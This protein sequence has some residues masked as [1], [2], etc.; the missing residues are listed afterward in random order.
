MES[1]EIEQDVRGLIH[2]LMVE[3]HVEN[4]D[5]HFDG[6]SEAGDNYA[7][8]IL[9]LRVVPKDGKK[10]YSL[11]AKTAKRS[12]ELNKW[13]PI[14]MVYD[15]EVLVY[16]KIFPTFR[17]LIE[18]T[19][20]GLNFDF[21]PK[22]YWISDV[23]SKQTL[24]FENLK[25]RGFRLHDRK[26]PWNLEESL[27]AMERYGEFHALSMALRD[28][29]P[30]EYSKLAALMPDIAK[31][32]NK[33]MDVRAFVEPPLNSMMELLRNR[34]RDDL[35][36]KYEG[37][38]EEV[39][40]LMNHEVEN[41]SDKI[42]FGHADCWNNNFM[43]KYQDDD[44]SKPTAICLLDF[45]LCLSCSPVQDLS[46]NIYTTCDKTCLDHFDEL[47]VTY[48]ASLSRCLRKLGSEPDDI[49]TFEQLK[50]HWCKYGKFGLITAL[51]VLKIC[52]VDTED[53]PNF[54]DISKNADNVQEFSEALNIQVKNPEE[55]N[56]RLLDVF[57]HFGDNFL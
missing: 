55:Y 27:M 10:P 26:K 38:I 36:K 41:E 20:A 29:K 19:N 6:K 16:A 9:F 44:E 48:H 4:Y 7:G 52:L 34:G 11:V 45:Q 23:V 21:V 25:S 51:L 17:R 18:E 14:N 12:K 24:I 30:E 15:R 54:T 2:Q 46:Y 32:F 56:R 50:K 13:M 53:V 28:Q 8:E 31:E 33:N 37:F 40:D 35:V 42:V 57:V 47:L 5:V 43:F 49:F 22:V 3:E 39:E 1:D